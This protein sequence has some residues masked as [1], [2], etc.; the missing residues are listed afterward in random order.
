MSPNP[1]SVA[2]GLAMLMVGLGV[3]FPLAPRGAAAVGEAER[4]VFLVPPSSLY[5][6]GADGGE[7]AEIADNVALADN[8][9]TD[10][11]APTGF[12]PSPDGNEVA[13]V[14][15]GG[16][17]RNIYLVGLDGSRPRR[18]TRG[19]GPD[20]LLGWSPSGD[21]VVF[22]EVTGAKTTIFTIRRDGTDLVRLRT[23]PRPYPAPVAWSPSGDELAL[24]TTEAGRYGLYTM[25]PDGTGLRLL[26]DRYRGGAAWSPD[27]EEI[28]FFAPGPRIA[29][30][31]HLINADGTQ[32]RPLVGED[33]DIVGSGAP[34]WSP[35]GQRIAF[36]AKTLRSPDDPPGL[37]IVRPGAANAFREIELPVP[38]V[39]LVGPDEPAVWVNLDHHAPA[40]SWSPDGTGIAYRAGGRP[41]IALIDVASGSARF[42]TENEITEYGPRFLRSG[43]PVPPPSPQTPSPGIAVIGLV[44]AATTAVVGGVFVVVRRR[45]SAV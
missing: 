32:L 3:L 38:Y 15:T 4:L 42:I 28:A 24:G 7:W 8:V 25:R 31:P 2:S 21:R 13:Y 30:V 44:A 39:P 10:L 35:D 1:R 20:V 12:E 22:G 16:A 18:L 45:R 36:T 6:V 5:V 40:F 34:S 29:P 14:G 9:M 27:G 11:G 37:V 17:A 41:E 33:A 43:R 23:E 26:T 19:P